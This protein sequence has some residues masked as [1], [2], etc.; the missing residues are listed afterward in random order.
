MRGRTRT[1]RESLLSIVLGFEIIV[2]GL[3]ALVVF[4]LK[5]APGEPWYALVGGGVVIVVMIIA[6]A[7]MGRRAGVILGWAVQIVMVLSG[8][9][10][11]QIYFVAAMFLALWIYGNYKG[12][13]LDER[14]AAFRAQE[15]ENQG[16]TTQGE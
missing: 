2:V 5:A 8:I 7:L 10:V 9:L 12:A 3:T 16:T 4:G 13:Q 1:V 6:L 11:A 14:N 15:A